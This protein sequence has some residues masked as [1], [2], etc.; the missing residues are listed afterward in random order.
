M[1]M[2]MQSLIIS[3]GLIIAVMVHLWEAKLCCSLEYEMYFL[4]YAYLFLFVFIGPYIWHMEDPRLG[5]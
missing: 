1:L 2:V 4:T 5:V 3:C